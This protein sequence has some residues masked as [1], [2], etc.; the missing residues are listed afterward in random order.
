MSDNDNDAFLAACLLSQQGGFIGYSSLVR[1]RS[2]GIR[3]RL[4]QFVIDDHVV[5]EEPWPWGGEP[6]YRNGVFCGLT[7]S[8]SF[9]FGIDQHICLGYV[10]DY[11]P[12]TGEER[13]LR[14]NEF[15]N[16]EARFEVNIAGKLYPARAYLYPIPLPSVVEGH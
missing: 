15:V 16:K 10:H 14:T 12:S 3:K 13:L 7:T 2:E 9:G 5:D 6:I 11:D 4:L 8:T 1:Q